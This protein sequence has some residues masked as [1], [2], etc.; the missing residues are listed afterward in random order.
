MPALSLT[1]VARPATT[2]FEQFLL[3]FS[4]LLLFHQTY[5][6]ASCLHSS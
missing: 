3:R 4:A 6:P 2:R 5:T 1:G